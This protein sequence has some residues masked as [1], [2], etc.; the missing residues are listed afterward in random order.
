M[1]PIKSFTR[2]ELL[3]LLT[4]PDPERA[5][6]SARIFGRGTAEASA[7]FMDGMFRLLALEPDFPRI[8]Q[9]V[10]EARAKGRAGLY[11]GQANDVRR[12]SRVIVEAPTA[13][14]FALKIEALGR[15]PGAEP[16]PW[17]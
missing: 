12:V 8:E 9:M 11:P 17:P 10:E 16:W 14:E 4:G 1:A 15:E 5:L 6:A 7:G 2:A 3:Q 13:A